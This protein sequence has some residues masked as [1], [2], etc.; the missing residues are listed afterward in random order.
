MPSSIPRALDQANTSPPAI[1]LGA[2][3]RIAAD[4]GPGMVFVGLLV[5]IAFGTTRLID[6]PLLLFAL[7]A[8]LAG[9]FFA[10]RP[11]LKPGIDFCAKQV[12]YLGIILLGTQVTVLDVTALG[13]QTVALVAS[14]IAMTLCGGWVIGHWFNLSS[15]HAIMSAGAVAI[16]GGSAALAICAVLPRDGDRQNETVMTVLCVTVLS[17]LAMVFYPLI[18]SW[19]GMTDE[20]AGMFLGATIHNVA[21]VVGAGHIVSEQAAETATIVKLMR[22][23]C[24]VPVVVLISLLFVRNQ[25]S[26]PSHKKPPLLPYFLIGFLACMAV[27]SMGIIPAATSVY[28]GDLSQWALV[29]SI[30]ALG[31]QTSMKCIVTVGPKALA[32]MTVQ[33]ALLAAFAMLFILFLIA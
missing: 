18:A 24:L 1:D 31:A 32:A 5:A 4:Y 16:C 12:L 8:G 33:T 21:Q 11:S 13:W 28:L 20:T 27:N 7:F 9:S 14:G 6:G 23:S 19:A 25:A 3:R 15:S 10:A 29:A 30:A 17:T 2:F 22:V 26:A